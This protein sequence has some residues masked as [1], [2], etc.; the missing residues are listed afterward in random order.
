MITPDRA[1]QRTVEALHDYASYRTQ[2]SL[3]GFPRVLLKLEWEEKKPFLRA[4]QET[5]MSLFDR[6]KNFFGFGG[7]RLKAIVSYLRSDAF[8]KPLQGA[9]LQVKEQDDISS[10]LHSL[11]LKIKKYN[12]AHR[13]F[14]ID[15]K[16]TTLSK[17]CAKLMA[18][19]EELSLAH[20]AIKE[21][22][23]AIPS[24]H[25]MPFEKELYSH[26]QTGNAVISERGELIGEEALLK[27][28][29]A[30]GP[31]DKVLLERILSRAYVAQEIRKLYSRVGQK[32]GVLIASV[33]RVM[34]QAKGIPI[35]SM[36]SVMDA[37]MA[38]LTRLLEKDAKYQSLQKSS[39]SKVVKRVTHE[40]REAVFSLCGIERSKRFE[41]EAVFDAMLEGKIRIDKAQ[42]GMLKIIEED[43]KTQGCKALTREFLLKRAKVQ[44]K[45]LF[46]SAWKQLVETPLAQFAQGKMTLAT[47]VRHL[48]ANCTQM[49][50]CHIFLS[51]LRRGSWNDEHAF[52][53][54]WQHALHTGMVQGLKDTG[55]AL[56]EGI[57]WA[58][59]LRWTIDEIKHRQLGSLH[60]VIKKLKIGETQPQDRRIQALLQ[61]DKTPGKKQRIEKRMG[62]VCMKRDKFEGPVNIPKV[63]SSIINDREFQSEYK[64]I[65]QLSFWWDGPGHAITIHCYK[66][67]LNPAK[68]IFRFH[69]PNFGSFHFPEQAQFIECL[70]ELIATTYSKEIE[71]L[72]YRCYKVS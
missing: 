48:E 18:R 44:G 64:G 6:I 61:I 46:Q 19:S 43:L 69:E 15:M 60:D 35:A 49:E 55:E 32:E 41:W 1:F 36:S 66:N 58:L 42:T 65:A 13:F 38:R 10:S 29:A 45:H 4:V 9:M 68:S 16:D 11:D 72:E 27:K 39:F 31:G 14:K 57:C 12:A 34:A 22:L 24:I 7:Y 47:F 63:L 5:E 37:Q 23:L 59:S 28:Q 17:T 40:K 20:R 50:A 30:F 3:V 52:Y 70:S 54:K 33:Q 2:E 56:G 53:L 8:C 62:A 71:S 51:K 26:I 21:A 67:P 25:E